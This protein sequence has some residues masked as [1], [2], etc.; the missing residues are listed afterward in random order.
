MDLFGVDVLGNEGSAV[1]R[2]EL[3]SGFGSDMEL[4]E[5]GG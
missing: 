3:L 1:V 2:D 5:A 4:L